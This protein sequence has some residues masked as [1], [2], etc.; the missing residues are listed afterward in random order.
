LGYFRGWW[1][2]STRTDI[3]VEGYV[4]ELLDEVNSA[5]YEFCL[6]YL[7]ELGGVSVVANGVAL[8]YKILGTSILAG[9]YLAC[10]RILRPR[11]PWSCDMFDVS[12]H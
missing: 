12:K 6:G 9:L 10:Q 1:P 7:T 5:A 4:V 2:W 8:V 11:G 3:L